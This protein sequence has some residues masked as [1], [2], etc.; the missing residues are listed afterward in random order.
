[1][2]SLKMEIVKKC[3]SLGIFLVGFAP[4]KRWKNPPEELPNNLSPW[5]PEEFWPQSI[6]PEAR[7]VIVIGLPVSLPIVETAPSIYYM[8]LYKTINSMLDSKSCE[9]ANFLNE[10][11]HSSIY[12]PR[13]G[14]G[15]IK[16]LIEKPFAF[17]SCRAWI[18][19][20]Q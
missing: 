13:D 11:G 7:T 3:K 5:I 8:E 1:M 17:F 10:K 4:V 12:L 14:Y 15:D 16:V 2:K 19:W 18:L 20:P 9:I 6:Y